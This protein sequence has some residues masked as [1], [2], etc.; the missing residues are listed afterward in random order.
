MKN[1]TINLS[2]F[3]YAGKYVINENGEIYNQERNKKVE[4]D[5]NNRVFI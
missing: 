3:G 4:T 2:T 5:K 1:N